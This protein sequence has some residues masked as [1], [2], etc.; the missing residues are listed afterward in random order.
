VVHLAIW[1]L[2]GSLC[3]RLGAKRL[4]KVCVEQHERKP[5]RRLWA[6]R[7]A[8]G[9]NPIRWR[10]C[11]V[12]GLAP[13]PVLR[14]IPRWLALLLVTASSAAIA[15]VLAESFAPGSMAA[16]W[17]LDVVQA[18]QRLRWNNDRIGGYVP[19]MG[20]IFVLSGT[21]LVGV[22]CGTSVAEE[23]RRNTWDDLLL[24]AQ[25]FREIT[26]GKMW[27]VLQGTLPY[28]I[29]YALPV[30]VFAAAGGAVAVLAAAAWIILP[31]TIVFVAALRGID[32][33]RVPPDMDETRPGGAFW[34]EKRPRRANPVWID[35][36][37]PNLRFRI[38]I[39]WSWEDDA[40][41]AEVPDLQ[42]CTARG[43]TYEE[44]VANV[45]VVM[46]DWIEMARSRRAEGREPPGDD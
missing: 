5:S 37:E 23:K 12:I 14:I 18:F 17:K 34:F 25:S 16:L 27:G 42:G 19:I 15:G 38:V 22:R 11:Y 7:P 40:Y 4:R 24:T 41:V 31:C 39:S 8:V 30:F 1:T 26:T 46:R 2:L 43:R 10:E 35:R 33:I 36:M 3:A 20:M 28:I 9:D 29:A 13:L 45:E 6:F 32:M 21:V 44:A